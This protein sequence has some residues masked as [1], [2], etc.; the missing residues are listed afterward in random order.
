MRRVRRRFVIFG[1]VL[2]LLIIGV[3]AYALVALTRSIPQPSLAPAVLP[4]A[5]PGR[6][7]GVEWPAVGESALAVRGVGFIGARGGDRP[8]AIASVAKIMTAYIVLRDH[9]LTPGTDGPLL[10]VTPA[11]VALYKADLTLGESTV[12]VKAGEVLTERQALEA[13][14]LPSANNVATLLAEWDAGSET[15][16]VDK[17]NQRARAMGLSHTHYADASGF[18]PATVSTARDQVRLALLAIRLPAF[19]SIVAT[20]QVIL[21]VVGLER[22]LDALLGS[23]GI[24]GIKT[25]TTNSAG[26]CFVL[27]AHLRVGRRTVTVA[28]A[29]MGQPASASQPTILDAALHAAGRLA[30]SVPHV[31]KRLAVL[32]RG[33]TFARIHSAWAQ[34][35][36][37][38][39]AHVPAL[40]GWPG[41]PVTITVVPQLPLTAP[42]QRGQEVAYATVRA[43]HQRARMA[44]VA[45]RTL[46]LPSLGWRLTHP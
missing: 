10:T 29:V 11:D 42:V 30:K 35:V 28:G 45:T 41:L 4:G 37:V 1:I 46:P 21:P 2:S 13:L 25:G 7:S 5:F 12:Q 38:R 8:L 17:M 15:A 9:P 39:A 27:A 43:G 18:D 23:D 19:A 6:L 26:G 20:R 31:L 32:A 14:M 33:R 16:F 44:L 24:I 22:N 3:V 36:A 34:P 40:V